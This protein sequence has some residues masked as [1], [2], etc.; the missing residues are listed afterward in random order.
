MAVTTT[1]AAAFAHDP[2]W[3]F[4][5][6][7]DYDRLAPNFAR[8]LFDTRV[9]SGNVWIVD[10]VSAVA[11]WD[12]PGSS[13]SPESE[14]LWQAYRGLAG[15]SAW[16][17]LSDYESALDAVRPSTPYWY[18]GVLAT[19]PERQNHGLATAVM[20]PILERADGGGLDCCLETSTISNRQ[21]YGH[22][23]FTDTTDVHV[24]SGPPTWWLRRAPRQAPGDLSSR[25]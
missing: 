8:A 2:A 4:L 9:D 25:S 12:P 18:L 6:G 10:D 22:R 21:F 20:T 17:R 5:C 23:G 1:V 13:P 15:E 16:K 24:A 11:M 7:A 19:H 3:S 14:Q